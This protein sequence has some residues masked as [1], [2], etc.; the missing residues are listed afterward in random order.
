MWYPIV[1]RRE[2]GSFPHGCGTG[3]RGK[4]VR[5]PNVKLDGWTWLLAFWPLWLV[6]VWPLVWFI[7]YL[8]HLFC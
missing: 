3:P 5:E 2:S 6:L 1:A 4:R 8:V 7:V